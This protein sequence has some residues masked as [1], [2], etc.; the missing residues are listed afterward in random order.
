MIH[1]ITVLELYMTE[2]NDIPLAHYTGDSNPPILSS[3]ISVTGRQT[4]NISL[5][6]YKIYNPC[7]FTI[8]WFWASGN[9]TELEASGGVAIEQTIHPDGPAVWSTNHPAP[10]GNAATNI[11]TTSGG[12]SQYVQDFINWLVVILCAVELSM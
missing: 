12:K 10:V 11:T 4:Y 1:C 6:P 2:S 7:D 3:N 9:Y 5:I 8:A